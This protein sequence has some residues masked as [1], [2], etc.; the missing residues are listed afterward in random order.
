[1]PVYAYPQAEIYLDLDGV[2]ADFDRHLHDPVHQP[3]KHNNGA[4][5]WDSLDHAW[6]ETMPASPGAK[7]FH[8]YCRTQAPTRFLTSPTLSA[9]CF[10][11]K[12]AWITTFAGHKAA[13][14]D[15]IIMTDKELMAAPHRILVDDR[16]SKIDAW[17]ASGG[18]GILHTGDFAVTQ[19]KLQQTLKALQRHA[20]RPAPK[21]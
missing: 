8:A 15:L 19:A 6:W 11:G 17:V 5:I 21:S 10:G 14:K 9:D 2:I 1:M 3:P 18:I 13:L 7:A 4:P 16:Q 12:A 20:P